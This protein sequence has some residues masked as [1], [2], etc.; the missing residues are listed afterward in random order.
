MKSLGVLWLIVFISL[1]GFGVTAVPFPLVAEQMGASNFWKTFGGA[2]VFSLFQLVAT[3]LWGRWSD[4]LGRKPILLLSSAGSV[5]AYLWLAYAD[6]LTSLIVARAFG[7]IMSGNLSAAFA[8]ATDVTDVKNRARGLGIVASA[9]GVGFAVGPPLGGFLGS[10]DGGVPSLHWPA[11]ASAGLS[12]LALL[13]TAFLLRESLAPELRKPLRPRGAAATPAVAAGP[14]RSPFAA[15]AARP[16]LAGLILATLV[17]AVGGG[18]MQSVFQ[19]WGRDLFQFTL[20]DIGLQFMVFALLSAVGQAGLIGPLARR[21][22]EKPIAIASIIGV[23]AGLL[24]F[25]VATQVWMVWVG[26][27][28]F[29]LANGLF[30]PAVTSL[31]SFEADPRNRGAVMGLFNAASSAGRIVGPAVSGPV[32][33]NVGVAAPFVGSAVLTAIG[34]LLLSRAHA[35]TATAVAVTGDDA[36]PAPPPPGDAIR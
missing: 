19:F 1:M 24:T 20:R 18:S 32:Y 17:V 36:P 15:L 28:I 12:L 3:P 13:G 23:T 7:G 30:L 29:G 22:G 2:G 35:P 8:Y 4:T 31:V 16:V 5:I 11:L 26:I 6:T 25:A 33:F 34:A 14:R 21:F 9:F 10:V 27:A